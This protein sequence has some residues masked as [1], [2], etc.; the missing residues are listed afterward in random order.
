MFSCAARWTSRD[1][2]TLAFLDSVRANTLDMDYFTK[3]LIIVIMDAAMNVVLSKIKAEEKA[4]RVLDSMNNAFVNRWNPEDRHKI[5]VYIEMRY[6]E[7]EDVQSEKRG[8]N[9]LW[10]LSHPILKNLL[11]KEAIGETPRDAVTLTS[12]AAYYSGR[13]IAFD[14]VV[15]N[16]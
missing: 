2:E 8:P 5:Q 14:E 10:P 1:V 15:R 11:G 16:L 9:Q 6:N 7:Y 4:L 13:L 3:E 12:I